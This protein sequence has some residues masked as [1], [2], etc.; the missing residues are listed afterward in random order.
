[1]SNLVQRLSFHRV[2]LGIL[3]RHNANNAQELFLQQS[4]SPQRAKNDD[5]EDWRDYLVRMDQ[6]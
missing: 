6:L 4:S 5:R 2:I 3:L 1:M